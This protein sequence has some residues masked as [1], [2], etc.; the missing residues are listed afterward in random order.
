MRWSFPSSGAPYLGYIGHGYEEPIEP[1]LGGRLIAFRRGRLGPDRIP[2]PL[3]ILEL[4]LAF[5]TDRPGDYRI[6]NAWGESRVLKASS[7]VETIPDD[8]LWIEHPH[9]LLNAFTLDDELKKYKL[10]DTDGQACAD[11]AP[12]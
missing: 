12:S 7:K 1:G 2:P 8:P 11:A 5:L 4:P 3:L 10:V 6:V 9:V